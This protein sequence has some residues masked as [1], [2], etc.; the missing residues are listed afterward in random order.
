[1]YRMSRKNNKF[2]AFALVLVWLVLGVGSCADVNAS[3]D[4]V[5]SKASS[6]SSDLHIEA[7]TAQTISFDSTVAEV[8][9]ANPEIADVQMNS[10]H[11]AYIFAKKSGVTTFIATDQNGKVVK[12]IV[13]TVSLNSSELKRLLK[14]LNPTENVDIHT[15]PKGIILKGKVSS[16]RVAKNM[17]D[18]AKRFLASDTDEVVNELSVMQPTQVMIKVKI[19]E[20]NR[21]VLNELDINWT[22]AGPINPDN[23]IMFG[24]LQGQNAPL[25]AVKSFA[26]P[27]SSLSR[28]GASFVNNRTSLTALIDMIASEQ[29]GT[30]LAEPNLV[31]ISGET[32]S[33]LA[34]GEFPIPVPQDQNV[35]I[36]FKQFGISLAFTPTVLSE[37][38]INMRVRPEVSDLDKVN[39]LSYQVGNGTVTIPAIATRRVETTIELASGQSFAIAGLFKNNL[40]SSVNQV[41]GLGDIPILGALFRSSSF[42]RNESELV[43]IATPYIIEPTSPENFKSPTEDLRMASQIETILNGEISKPNP[44]SMVEQPAGSKAAEGQLRLVGTSGF[45]HE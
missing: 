21:T 25:S 20:V 33:F 7:N 36:E 38:Q 2:Q 44:S 22:A 15:T 3:H 31:A 35:T 26:R 6:K 13:I 41:P 10:P 12:N 43:V 24:L 4:R 37:N 40:T 11:I 30:I 27:T 28:F 18:V 17:V 42:A 8:F 1:M 32:A 39:G 9:I 16:S 19:A 29:L 5:E 45:Y 14:K 34:G 23:P